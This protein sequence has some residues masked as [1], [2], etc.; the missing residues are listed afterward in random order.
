MLTSS[1]RVYTGRIINLDSAT[2]TF[3]NGSSGELEMIRHPGA[4]AVVP[5]LEDPG[6]PDPLVVYGLDDGIVEFDEDD[7]EGETPSAVTIAPD[8]LHK[9]NTSGG[10]AYAMAIP[11][12]RADGELLHERHSL[13]FV[14]YL[15]LCFEYGGFPGYEGR[16]GAPAELHELKAGLIAF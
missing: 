14:D 2:V 7:E 9:T 8:E 12:R 16:S 5:F 10:D 3:P 4:C 11:D 15:R 13:L 1:R 6:A